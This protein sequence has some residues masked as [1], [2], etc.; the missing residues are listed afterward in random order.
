VASNKCN[1]NGHKSPRADERVGPAGGSIVNSLFRFFKKKTATPAV[2]QM[3][4]DGI[5]IIPSAAAIGSAL[6]I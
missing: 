3:L 1:P 4:R 5:Q 6:G 2:T